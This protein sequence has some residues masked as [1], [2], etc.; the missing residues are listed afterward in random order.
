MKGREE[1]VPKSK[2]N[3]KRASLAFV[4]ISA[5]YS[6]KAKRKFINWSFMDSNFV[7]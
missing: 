4:G 2:H 5:I 1:R 3:S 6:Y 7:S